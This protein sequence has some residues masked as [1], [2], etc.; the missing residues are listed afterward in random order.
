MPTVA[1][2]ALAAVT[3]HTQLADF[4]PDSFGIPAEPTGLLLNSITPK[5]T[6]SRKTH[7]DRFGFEGVFKYY[8]NPNFQLEVDGRDYFKTGNKFAN[9]H[10]GTPISRA[11]VENY[12][13]GIRHGF[14]DSG[15]FNFESID[16]GVTAAEL[17][18]CK[19]TLELCWMHD[20]SVQIFTPAT[21]VA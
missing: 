8:V 1:Y 5:P 20:G 18:T 3:G 6:R 21:A 19:F 9:Q 7:A 16:P 4:S 2:N 10:P 12:V 17:H 11:D 15:Y 14:P 13:P